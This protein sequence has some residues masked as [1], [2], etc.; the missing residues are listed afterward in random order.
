M[1]LI[2]FFLIFN[3]QFHLQIQN[4]DLKREL[5]FVGFVG[6]GTHAQCLVEAAKPFESALSALDYH[7]F[8]HGVLDFCFD[9][10]YLRLGVCG[11]Y[12]RQALIN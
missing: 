8:L 6:R 9:F 11:T 4:H 12:H 10:Q 7:Y 1:I 5:F 2:L 3:Q